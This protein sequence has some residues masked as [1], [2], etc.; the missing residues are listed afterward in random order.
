MK[1]WIIL[2][3]IGG[4]LWNP[5]VAQNTEDKEFNPK[6]RGA[7]MMGNSHVPH[8]T[9]GGKNVSIIPSWGCDLDYF[10]HRRWS[11]AI[12]GDFKLQSFEVEDGDAELSRSYPMTFS[13][14]IHY[15]AL[16]HW[17]FYLGPGYEF[18][19]HRDLFVGKVGTEYSFEI[20][21]NFEIAL[22][23]FFGN[24]QEVQIIPGS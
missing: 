21:E 13:D 22:N 18:E 7:V 24:K 16:R 3:M 14:V 12:Q 15:H 9:E 1:N 10:F 4:F 19:Q 23:L 8:A 2:V 5:S 17:S 11:V 6:I 20:N